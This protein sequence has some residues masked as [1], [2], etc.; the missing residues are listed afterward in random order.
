MSS[1]LG[2]HRLPHQVP[3]SKG[4]LRQES[5]SRLPFPSPGD[6]PKPGIEP[7]SPALQADSLPSQP[8]GK[9]ITLKGKGSLGSLG[10]TWTPCLYLKWIANEVLLHSTGNS[11][12]C[13][14]AAWM[15]GEFGGEWV[16]VYI[17]WVPSLFTWT[18]TILLAI[19]QYK[20]FLVLK[21]VLSLQG[22]AG[23]IPGQGTKI[24]HGT[25]AR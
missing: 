10:W 11:A 3:L 2:S 17:G 9:P 15:G 8:P 5:W 20:M 25:R 13:Y 7:G 18:I 24:P 12:Q 19:P 22:D 14:V 6:V 23:W 1:S 21:T 4:F 16:H